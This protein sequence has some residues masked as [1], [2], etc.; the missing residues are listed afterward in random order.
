MILVFIL[1]SLG[2]LALAMV[3]TSRIT[4]IMTADTPTEKVTFIPKRKRKPKTK[5]RVLG[6]IYNKFNLLRKNKKEEKKE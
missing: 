1:K 3:S 2:N 6:S 4:V 5:L